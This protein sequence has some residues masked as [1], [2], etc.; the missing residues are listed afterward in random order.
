MLC[1][2]V[3]FLYLQK[4]KNCVIIFLGYNKDVVTIKNLLNRLKKLK[5]GK[6]LIF[7][8]IILAIVGTILSTIAFW[9]SENI[10]PNT[11][12]T[13][14]YK[15]TVV[16]KFQSPN[17]WKPGDE[18]E[19]KVTVKN[20]GSTCVRARA[21]YTEEWKDKD[22]NNLSLENNGKRVAIINFD[23]T[24]DWIKDGDYYYYQQDLLKNQTSTS[25]I[26]SVTYNKELSSDYVC[27]TE[28]NIQKCTMSNGDYDGAEYT[29]TI[30]IE[31][32]QCDGAD[33][34]WTESEGA[35]NPDESDPGNTSEPGDTNNS[36]E[37]QNPE[38]I[39]EP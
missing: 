9:Q 30:K 17:D 14:D 34:I 7:A 37:S 12:N 6:S 35:N 26:K 20:E 29:L 13:S 32:V 28:G 2:L 21:S 31:M 11:F 19:K 3:S 39:T 33:E 15:T 4:Y 38:E 25:F 23:N 22:G 16:E 5:K 36:D 18:T 8:G 1:K 24:T 27:T 10:F